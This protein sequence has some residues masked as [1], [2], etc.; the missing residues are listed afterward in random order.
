MSC[1][2]NNDVCGNNKAKH[3]CEYERDSYGFQNCVICHQAPPIGGI[4]KKSIKV[5][6]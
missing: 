6:W 1:K 5:S 2:C 3:E 4:K